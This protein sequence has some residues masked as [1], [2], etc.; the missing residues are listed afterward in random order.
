MVGGALP[1]ALTS[2]RMLD[3]R[4]DPRG[5]GAQIMCAFGFEISAPHNNLSSATKLV[6]S[7]SLVCDLPHKSSNITAQSA[8][9]KVFG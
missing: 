1:Q 2:F 9:Y 5:A 3:D 7:F 6:G 4:P 8:K